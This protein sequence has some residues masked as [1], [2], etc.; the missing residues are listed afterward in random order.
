MHL[1]LDLCSFSNP[2]PTFN[3]APLPVPQVSRFPPANLSSATHP[4]PTLRQNAHSIRRA[5]TLFHRH[6]YLFVFGTC[7]GFLLVCLFICVPGITDTL[8]PHRRVWDRFI[9]RTSANAPANLEGPRTGGSAAL[10]YTW[11]R[12]AVELRIE[13][14]RP[15]CTDIDER[16]ARW[17]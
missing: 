10:T 12:E 6:S 15:N 7:I 3:L 8:C 13:M 5:R 17:E 1:D 14:D 16:L 11:T 4:L 9:P 2:L